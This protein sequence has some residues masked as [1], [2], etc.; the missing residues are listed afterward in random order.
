MVMVSSAS[1]GELRQSAA[2]A[3]KPR[4]VIF[5]DFLRWLRS[6]IRR[7]RAPVRSREE[8]GWHLAAEERDLNASDKGPV[9]YR[10][11]GEKG[12]EAIGAVREVGGNVVDAVDKS[13]KQSNDT[14]RS[15]S[16]SASASCSEPSG[17]VELG[18]SKR[19]IAG[20][21]ISSKGPGS[22]VLTQCVQA[23]Y[24]S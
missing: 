16:R 23:C 17:D 5:V 2:A 3:R 21:E 6:N 10:Y 15:R 12:R 18:F 19:E 14:P 24:S 13:L 22:R 20:I 9:A 1:A 4:P 11:A 8:Q 7:R